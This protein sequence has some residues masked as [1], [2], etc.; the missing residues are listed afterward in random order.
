MALVGCDAV[1][2]RDRIVLCEDGLAE[3]FEKLASR[4]AMIEANQTVIETLRSEL[5][6]LEEG[7]YKDLRAV[8]ARLLALSKALEI[9]VRNLGHELV[10]FEC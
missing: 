3:L 5:G 2:F 8:E 10:G 9:A 7:I 1:S 4:D 6:S